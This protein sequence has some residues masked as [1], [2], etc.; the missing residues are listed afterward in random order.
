MLRSTQII[1]DPI[2][3]YREAPGY[4]TFTPQIKFDVEPYALLQLRSD[5]S[6]TGKLNGRGKDKPLL[7]Y[8][9]WELGRRVISNQPTIPNPPHAPSPD[10]L[11]CL[12]LSRDGDE[13]RWET[14]LDNLARIDELRF[15]Q[16]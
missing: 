12:I 10:K 8:G 16:R 14:P 6:A 9:R 13:W 7:F 4:Y 3:E 15:E 11:V 2:P 5:G 1:I